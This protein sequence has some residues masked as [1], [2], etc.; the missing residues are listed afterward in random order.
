MAPPHVI[1]LGLL[2]NGT[3]ESSTAGIEVRFGYD[4]PAY[5]VRA[6]RC[7]RDGCGAFHAVTD[8]LTLSNSQPIQQ[9]GQGS[10]VVFNAVSEVLG[11]VAEAETE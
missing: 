4:Q 8:Q 1:D 6:V 11:T 10:S 3:A 5:Q 9:V 7:E 2:R